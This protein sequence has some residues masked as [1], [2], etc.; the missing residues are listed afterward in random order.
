MPM[1]GG[2]PHSQSQPSIPPPFAG[3]VAFQLPLF[4][5]IRSDVASFGCGFDAERPELFGQRQPFFFGGAVEDNFGEGPYVFGSEFT[6]EYP[7]ASLQILQVY[8]IQHYS[9]YLSST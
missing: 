5:E 7:F 3:H 4:P 1:G 6:D 8:Q 9:A 2:R